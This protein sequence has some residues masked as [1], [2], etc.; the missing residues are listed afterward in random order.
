MSG[1]EYCLH[2]YATTNVLISVNSGTCK[3]IETLLGSVNKNVLS[4]YFPMLNSKFVRD[5]Q[6]TNSYKFM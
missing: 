3:E 1:T 2:R 6:E 4:N 5:T